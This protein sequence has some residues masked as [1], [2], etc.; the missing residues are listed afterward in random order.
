MK[1]ADV[2]NET[3][4]YLEDNIMTVQSPKEVAMSV[5]VSTSYL[6]NSF[7]M[8][9]GYTIGEYV[10]SRRLYLAAMDLLEKDEK[11]IDIAQKYGYETPESFTKAFSRFH[12]ATPTE[13]KKKKKAAKAF[14]PLKLSFSVKGADTVDVIIEKMPKFYILGSAEVFEVDTCFKKIP[15]FVYDFINKNYAELNA[16]VFYGVSVGDCDVILNAEG[17]PWSS[18]YEGISVDERFLVLTGVDYNGGKIPEGMT[19]IEIP[20]TLWAKFICRDNSVEASQEMRRY[21]FGE[22][23]F[24]TDEYDLIDE[25]NVERYGVPNE[26]GSGLHN[27]IWLPVRRQNK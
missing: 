23:L 3:L 9:T 13:I 2:I 21:I 8:I 5:H 16:N 27:E 17:R 15:G 4:R 22:W 24:E 26:D 25:Y 10:R 7:Q 19:V 20:E 14:L 12:D 6:Q 1:W 18:E 11:I